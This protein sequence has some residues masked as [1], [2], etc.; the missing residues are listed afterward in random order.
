MMTCQQARNKRKIAR[1]FRR[2]PP[3]NCPSSQLKNRL[4]L[5]PQK[6]DFHPFSARLEAQIPSPATTCR[7]SG[8]FARGD[9]YL[10]AS[11][12]RD[13]GIKTDF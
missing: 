1:L 8:S 5:G 3:S 9:V 10:T 13:K 11:Y 2:K 7:K 4:I 6:P 12:H